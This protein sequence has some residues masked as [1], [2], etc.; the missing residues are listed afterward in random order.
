MPTTIGAKFVLE[1]EKEYKQ[2]IS[3]INE[4]LKVLNSEMKLSASEFENQ[5]DSMEAITAQ[6]KILTDQIEEQK[7]K[8]AML[9]GAMEQSAELNGENAKQTKEWEISLNK[10][11]AELNKMEG[12][13]EKN[14]EALQK[15]KENMKGLGDALD[16][17]TGKF[18]INMPDGLKKTLNG[19]GEVNENTVALV[20]GFA[21]AAAGVVKVEK[22]LIDLTKEAA[23]AAD[24]I[25]TLSSQTGLAT[26]TIQEMQYASELLDVS[27]ETIQGILTKLT[28]NMQDTAAGTGKAKEAFAQL[29]ISVTDA[30]G[31]LRN[32]EEVFYEI[33]DALGEVSNETERDAL[34]MDIFGKK[35]QDLNPLIEQ[36]A[37]R[38]SELADEAHE[39]GYVMDEEMLK[40]LGGVDDAMQRMDNTFKTVKQNLAAQFAPYL[41]EF[42][43]MS[44]DV[45]LALGDAAADSGLVDFFGAILDLV[46]ALLPAIKLLTPVFE[47]LGVVLKPV[48]AV[49]SEIAGVLKTILNFAGDLAKTAGNW[50]GGILSGGG[51]TFTE[52]VIPGN[53]IGSDNWR[54]G[55]T[56]VGENG[57]ELVHLPQG[58]RIDTAQQSGMTGAVFNIVIDAKNVKEFNDI[59]RIAQNARF[60]ARMGVT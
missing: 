30:N 49:L 14:N 1:G 45:V 27:F 43:T 38:L 6:N 15:N 19:M 40:S 20:A 10:A 41:E 17:L 2:A 51:R 46:T 28:N 56:W 31:N 25:L 50:L 5:A 11:Q 39:V 42:F 36:G 53:E 24:E 29:G 22:A 34:S 9:R 3:E 60:E 12:Q 4:N 48:S 26:D 33:V 37:E 55:L 18:G 8:I 23:A 58:S 32:A 13:L 16:D 21:A 7:N 44:S 54:G 52:A 35:A 47:L 59:V 57:P